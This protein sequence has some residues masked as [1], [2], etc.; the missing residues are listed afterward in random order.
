MARMF[1]RRTLSGFIPADEPSLELMRKYKLGQVYRADIVKPRSYAHHKLIFA[2]LTL[3]FEN[4]DRFDNFEIFRKAV[5]FA[6]GHVTEYPSID[7]EIIREPAS[8]SY[9]SLDEVQFTKVAGAMMTVCAH[10]LHDMNIV[11]LERQVGIYADEKY[12]A[13]AA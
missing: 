9:D 4:Q 1:L 11:E 6:A 8:I 2:L 5:T 13:A 12:G 10:I 7:G 3:T